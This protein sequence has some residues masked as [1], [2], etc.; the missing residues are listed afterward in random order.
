[1]ALQG[2]TEAR[3]LA[4]LATAEGARFYVV[5]C[6]QLLSD[7]R[8]GRRVSAKYAWEV[9]R[10]E[11]KVKADNR[12]HALAI[13]RAEEEYPELQQRAEKRKRKSA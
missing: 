4:W 9:G 3:F 8:D 5:F 13:R 6:G 11:T 10:R 7:A 1:M 2:T 12:F